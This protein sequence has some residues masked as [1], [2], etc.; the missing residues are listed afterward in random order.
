M[1][2]TCRIAPGVDSVSWEG[3]WR[4]ATQRRVV[5]VMM[6]DPECLPT[7]VT[8]AYSGDS[9]PLLVAKDRRTGMTFAA[10]VLMKGGDPHAARL[11]AKW[12]DGLGCQEVT[13]RTHGEPSICELIRRVREHR[14]EGTTTVDEISPPGDSASNG[15]AERAI[16]TAGSLVRTKKALVEENALESRDAGPRLTAWMVHHTT[17]VIC[18]SMVGADG[19]TPFRRLKER[20]FGTP[21]AGFGERVWLRDLVL[22]R[23]NKFNR[24]PAILWWTLTV[25]FAWCEQSRE[26]TLTT[27]GKL[28][29]QGTLS[30]PLIWSRRQPSSRAR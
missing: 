30:R 27:D 26:P 16:L 19:L 3:G 9:T 6:T 21:L 2:L 24:H 15:I 13:F 29:H 12:I 17:Q 20:K 10:V 22:E 8:S 18:A 23:A 1:C 14:A 28:C 11:L 7:T 5:T 4:D 25:D